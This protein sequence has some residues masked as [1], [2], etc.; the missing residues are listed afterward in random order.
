MMTGIEI[1]ESAIIG[2][3]LYIAHLGNIV[4]GHDTVIGKHASI[5]QGVTFGGHGRNTEQCG[6]PK[7]GDFV[8]FGAGAKIV[9]GVIIGNHVMIGCNAVV[10]KDIPDNGTAVGIPARVVNYNGSH[11]CVHYRGET[12][13]AAI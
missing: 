2:E 6:F 10:V 8:Y 1:H 11:G 4:I 9:G 5:H 7:S 3:G 13:D 12:L